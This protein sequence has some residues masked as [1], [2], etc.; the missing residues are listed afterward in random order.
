MRTPLSG[1][2]QP[3]TPPYHLPPHSPPIEPS[4]PMFDGMLP[5][6]ALVR[7]FQAST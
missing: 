3:N 6:F 7:S 5:P 2:F 4:K 1:E